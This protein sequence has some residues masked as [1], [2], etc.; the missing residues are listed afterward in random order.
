ML[1]QNTNKQDVW[2]V[3]QKLDS[4]P[5]HR[6]HLVSLIPLLFLEPAILYPLLLMATLILFFDMAQLLRDRSEK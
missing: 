6:L 3:S 1:Y 2:V 4:Y 5:I